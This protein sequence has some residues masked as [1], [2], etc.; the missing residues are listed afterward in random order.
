MPVYNTEE[1]RGGGGGG[2]GVVLPKEEA[3][4]DSDLWQYMCKVQSNELRNIRQNYNVSI[5]SSQHGNVTTVSEALGRCIAMCT[6]N[7]Y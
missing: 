1:M 3:C 2:G 5:T 6:V 4:V 7:A